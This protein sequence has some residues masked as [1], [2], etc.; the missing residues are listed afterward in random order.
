MEKNIQFSLLFV[1]EMVVFQV[2][3]DE[4]KVLGFYGLTKGL[5]DLQLLYKV[6][7]EFMQKQEEKENLQK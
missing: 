5:I 3:F 6:L 7:N 2:F 4:K 1:I